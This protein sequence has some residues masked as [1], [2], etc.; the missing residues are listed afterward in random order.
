MK[1]L[2]KYFNRSYK[3]AYYPMKNNAIYFLGVILFSL[4]SSTAMAALI[5]YNGGATVEA[6]WQTAAGTTVLEDFESYT[7]GEQLTDL[8]S[9][10]LGFDTLAGGGTPNIYRHHECCVTPYGTNHLGNFPNGIN[11]I[12]RWDDISMYV[13]DGYE[14][15][16]LGFWNGDGQ[17]DTLTASIYDLSNNFLGTVGAFKGT[18]AG[19]VSDVAISRV[20]FDGNTGDGWNHLDGLQTNVVKTVPEPETMFLLMIGLLGIVMAKRKQ[21]A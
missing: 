21:W 15:T 13:L 8:P 3:V 16:A 18:F 4:W 5:I 19:F 11:S 1:D 10:G 7:V 20:V 2:V 14:I 17:A 12:N 9:L 6:D